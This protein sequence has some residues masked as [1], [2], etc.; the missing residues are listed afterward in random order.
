MAKGR[1]LRIENSLYQKFILD[2]IEKDL[3]GPEICNLLKEKGVKISIP[4][5]NKFIKNVKRNGLN[6]SQFKA[7]T[8]NTALTINEKLKSI[9][10]LTTIFTRRNN[11]IETLLERREKLLEYA[12][13]GKRTEVLFENIAKI[14]DIIEQNKKTLPLEDYQKVM[15]SFDFLNSFI[16]GNF[17]DYRP[18][19]NVEDLIRKYTLDIHEVCKYIEQWTS[20]YEVESLMERLCEILTKSAVNT[21]GPL[22][23]RE[24]KEYRNSIIKKFIKEAEE[25]LNELKKFDI[26]FGDIKN[27]E[28]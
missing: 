25:A 22:L 15:M 9:P 13:E 23:K 18:A 19:T 28:R 4:T 6:L 11:L 5:I 21:F 2:C 7:E 24:T 16:K 12:D 14:R 3:K 27:V 10:E 1:A 20:K 17:K 8:E 26:K